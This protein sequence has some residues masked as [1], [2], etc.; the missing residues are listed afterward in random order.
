MKTILKNVSLKSI[1]DVKEGELPAS[2]AI[3]KRDETQFWK[4][5]IAKKAGKVFAV[6][7]VNLREPTNLCS[8]DINYYG[9]FLSNYIENVDAFLE[10]EIMDV[11]HNNGGEDGTYFHECT[12]FDE[13]CPAYMLQSWFDEMKED[14]ESW[15]ESQIEIERC[16]PTF[17]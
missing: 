14:G 17:C 12:F 5:D 13:V 10:D 2:W 1:T 16:N 4:D 7:F 9:T 15:E 11:E 6:Y 8:A 3:V